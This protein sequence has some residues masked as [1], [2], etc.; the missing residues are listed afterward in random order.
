MPSALSQERG[1]NANARARL[2][3]LYVIGK[4]KSLVKG[5]WLWRPIAAY[6][7]HKY[8]NLTY[9]RRREHV[10]IFTVREH[11]PIF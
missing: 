2:C 5:R 1:W 9:E 10:P 8:G 3:V 6:R 4:A 11:I 7:N